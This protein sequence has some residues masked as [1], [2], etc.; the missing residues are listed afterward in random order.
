MIKSTWT[1][2]QHMARPFRSLATLHS[3]NFSVTI[4]SNL[5]CAQ[6]VPQGRN[7]GSSASYIEAHMLQ[8]GAF[9]LISRVQISISSTSSLPS[10][11]SSQLG[12]AIQPTRWSKRWATHRTQLR[13]RTRRPS[14]FRESASGQ[15]SQW[16]R[17]HSG[18]RMSLATMGER[19]CMN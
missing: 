15:A 12:I 16:Q 18:P 7:L 1:W 5:G 9:L 8:I 11:V 4:T 17:R 14:H 10:P 6:Q 13:R 3:S 2:T 19:Q